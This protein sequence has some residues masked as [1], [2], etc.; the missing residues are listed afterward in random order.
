ML[1]GINGARLRKKVLLAG[2]DWP[3]D[4]ERKEMRTK[5]PGKGTKLTGYIYSC[6]E[7]GKHCQV[8]GEDARNVASVQKAQMGEEDEGRRQGQ[9]LILYQMLLFV[10][11][12]VCNNYNEDMF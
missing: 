6:R 10:E 3:Y 5:R 7:T 4:P 9:A 1:V 11:V 8:D 2:Q 12:Y